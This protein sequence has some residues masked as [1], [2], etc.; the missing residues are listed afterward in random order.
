MRSRGSDYTTCKLSLCTSWCDGKQLFV[1]VVLFQ[2]A[3]HSLILWYLKNKYLLPCPFHKRLL[4]G[5][6]VSE[7]L[8]STERGWSIW[9]LKGWG[10]EFSLPPGSPCISHSS[11]TTWKYHG[12]SPGASL[13][14]RGLRMNHSCPSLQGLWIIITFPMMEQWSPEVYC[15]KMSHQSVV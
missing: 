9:D 5:K 1:C 6:D 12:D 15:N 8:A 7:E 11:H 4:S 14:L 13:L 10:M 3:L 2:P